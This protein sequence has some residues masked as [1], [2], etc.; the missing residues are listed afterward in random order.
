MHLIGTNSVADAPTNFRCDR[1]YLVPETSSP[2]HSAR[3]RAILHEE[4][5]DLILSMRDAD[6]FA[7]AESKA[8]EDALPG[9][10]PIGSPRAALIGY[11]KW[12]TFLFA[13][14][15]GLPFADSFAPGETGDGTA[16]AEFCRRVGYPLVAKPRCGAGS[17][18]VYFVLNAK[19]AAAM[20]RPDYLLQEYLGDPRELERY[21]ANL[22]GPVPLMTQA[23]NASYHSSWTMIAPDGSLS[24]IMMTDNT[25]YFAGQAVANR[26]VDDPDMQA[27]TVDYARALYAE[28][29]TGPLNTAFRHDRHG[30]W[31]VPEINLRNSGGTF[32]RF[33]FGLDEL[34]HIVR[35]FAPGF[36]FP[37]LHPAG[38]RPPDQSRKLYY[39]H[40]STTPRSK[41][42]RT[43]ASGHRPKQ[44]IDDPL[45]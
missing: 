29:G 33:L 43:P 6:T 26:R 41:R 2:D 7:L 1:C 37:E 14:R 12:Q 40:R 27:I 25:F 9:R 42:C 44:R 35:A 19:D 17:R 3:M 13:R 5:P 10:L 30:A 22:G 4:K 36:S 28:G 11:D 21:C 34:H 38:E 15:H 39:S 16:L 20:A 8:H 32:S 18:G 31:S 23:P 24:P 45:E